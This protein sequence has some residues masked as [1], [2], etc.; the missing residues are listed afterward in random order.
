MGPL[1]D[2]GWGLTR[3][4]EDSSSPLRESR[5]VGPAPRIYW[6]RRQPLEHLAVLLACHFE[7]EA[8]PHQSPRH[9]QV[10]MTGHLEDLIAHLSGE[11]DPDA[12]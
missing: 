2:S 4:A 8:C 12:S 11:D 9:C 7:H 5:Q 10:C 1:K 6:A 3:K